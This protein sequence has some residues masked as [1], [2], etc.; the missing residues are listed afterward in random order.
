[1][2]TANHYD[3]II[4]GA[5]L[6]G[7]T[8]AAQLAQ[9]G[10]RTL[11][12]ERNSQV[13]GRARTDDLD[14]WHFN[15][16]G[17]ALYRNGL[18][19]RTLQALGVEPDGATP[20][21]ARAQIE[22]NGN[23]TPLP[24]GFRSL[25]RTHAL[26]ATSKPQFARLMTSVPKLDPDAYSDVT[27]D[28]W[29]DPLRPDVQQIVKAL[30]RLSTYAAD[31][32]IMSA[33]AAIAQ[34]GGSQNGVLY[35]HGGWARLC[36]QIAK[37]ATT[38]G[39]SD[40]ETAVHDATIMVGQRVRSIAAGPGGYRVTT[41]TQQHS[42]ATVIVAAGGPALTASLLGV[43]PGH[44]GQAGPAPQAA[45]LDLALDAMPTN[46]R[47]VL[48][49]DKPT[50]FAVHSPPARLAPKGK[51]A[52][53]AMRYLSQND[54]GSAENHR[55]SLENLARIAGADDLVRSRFLRRMTVTNGMPTAVTGG[56]RG[57]PSSSVPRHPGVFIAGDWVGARG[58]L[59]DVAIASGHDAVIAAGKSMRSTPSG[60]LA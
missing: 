27:V 12:L 8:A 41:K 26:R 53:V 38:T 7:L 33:D 10:H 21:L 28:Q 23:T 46:H 48:G 36:D 60:T 17:H 42:A 47:F 32:N 29:L 49:L 11:V 16:G 4:I 5:G 9:A 34:L 50:Y 58:L 35:L 1:M 57:R 13:G 39:A 55:A 43:D 15:H 45:V 24:I 54:K 51:V 56:M 40:R 44:F 6:A 3:T 22:T 20:P 52:A 18:G 14:G 31:T 25:V 19:H 30:V 37:A 59:A 2:T